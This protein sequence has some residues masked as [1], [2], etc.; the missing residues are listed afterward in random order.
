M[1]A[2]GTAR[3]RVPPSPAR[4]HGRRRR[5]S[6]D[7]SYTARS[8]GRSR[9]RLPPARRHAPRRD[10][11][12]RRSSGTARRAHRGAGCGSRA[13]AR[14]N[15]GRRPRTGW[16]G[17]ARAARERPRRRTRDARAACPLLALVLGGAPEVDLAL[18]ALAHELLELL[19]ELLVG[20][21][22]RL[23][24]PRVLERLDRQ[25]DLAVV[26]DRGDLD[27]DAVPF[28]QVL[29]DVFDVVPVDLRD[30]DHTHPS[31]LELQERAVVLDAHDG[32]GDRG[33]NL[34]SDLVIL[35]F[36]WLGTP[37]SEAP[38]MRERQPRR[39]CGGG[40]P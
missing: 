33:A 40:L 10:T 5:G 18:L 38:S 28:A 9:R 12:T 39:Q 19:L 4:A 3:A 32:R 37:P 15:T 27:L 23:A 2:R 26:L 17:H 1:S 34:D 11:S 31:V 8:A 21:P 14:P 13:D 22:A 36:R 30:V 29:T 35:L 7:R 25:V 16:S 24:R 20:A 6:R